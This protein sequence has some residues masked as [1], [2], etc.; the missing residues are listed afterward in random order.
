LGS[1]W[2]ERRLDQVTEFIVDCPHSTPEWTSSGVLV[3]RNQYIRHGRLNLRDPSFTTEEGYANRI[4]RAVPKPSDLVFTREAPMGEVCQIPEGIK[5]CLGQRMVLIRANNELISPRYLLFALQSPYLQ[6]QIGWNEGTGTTVSN[7]RLPNINAFQIP[8]PSLKI[9]KSIAHILGTLD[10]KIELNRRMNETL[11][12]MA[13]TLFKSWFV[14]FD[15]VLDK[16]M[17]AGNPIP[18]TMQK[19]AAARKQ[20]GNKRKPLPA[21][22]A[23]HFPDSFVFDEEMGWIPEGWT[24]TMIASLGSVTTGKTPPKKVERAFGEDGLPFI[25]PTDVDDAYFST[26]TNRSL[27]VNG[28]LSIKKAHIPSGTICV[29]CIGSQMGKTIISSNDAATNQQINSIHVTNASFRNWLFLSLRSRRKEL[30]LL[31]SSGSTMPIVN[32]S[33][34]EKLT[35][36]EPNVDTL[37]SFDE[38]V[39]GLFSRILDGTV[40]NHEISSLRDTLLPKLLSGEL[41]VPDAEKLIEKAL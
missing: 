36:L 39:G 30:Y 9:Q 33:A 23:Q 12:G 31:G 21:H 20:L 28:A 37:V 24:S 27:T 13:Q 8:L 7:I 4:K 29:T 22:I 41:Q 2:P 15:P 1:K 5:C 11:E 25:T 38:V 35:V 32:K 19:R 10:D 14:D 17:D 3:L 16:A 6:H 26:A 40:Q 18:E 34:F